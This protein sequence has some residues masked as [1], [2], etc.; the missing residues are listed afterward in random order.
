MVTLSLMM[1]IS[2]SVDLRGSFMIKLYLSPKLLS[3]T[4]FALCLAAAPGAAQERLLRFNLGYS[5]ISA[6]QALVRVMKDGGI[7]QKNGLDATLVFIAGGTG[8]IQALIA[9]D[10]PI[11]VLSG[12]PSILARLQGADTLILAGLINIIDFSIITAPEVKRPQ[13]LKGRKMAVSRY[14]SST[15]FVARYALEKWGL[16]PDQDVAL[17][18]IGSQPARYAALKTGTVQGTVVG[19]PAEFIARRAGFNELATAEQ[20]NLA[21][22]NTCIVTTVA[23]LSR[24]EELIR[25]AMKAFVEGVHFFKTQRE[26]SLKS[27]DAFIRIGESGLMEETYQHYR[28]LFA[29]VPYADIRGPQNVLNEIAK[30]EPKAKSSKPEAFVENRFLKELEA[31]G[32]VQRLYR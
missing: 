19:P 8:V 27:L 9:G 21:Y 31:S 4:L 18:Q 3:I 28:E 15:D 20:L 29:R 17:L 6:S 32:I 25:R 10:V 2:T 26:A 12:E 22:P 5:S 16:V 13:D 1:A 23:A 30:K 7:L 11:A 14:G 24:N